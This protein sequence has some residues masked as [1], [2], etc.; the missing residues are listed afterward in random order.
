[1]AF[2]KSGKI[3]LRVRTD[4]KGILV[5]IRNSQKLKKLKFA[6]TFQELLEKEEKDILMQ[7]ISKIFLLKSKLLE[8]QEIIQKKCIKTRM[9]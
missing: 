6:T 1:M 4:S 2:F 7:K 5:S 3:V 9:E 8:L